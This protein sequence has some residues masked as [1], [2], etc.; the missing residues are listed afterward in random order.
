[1][2]HELMIDVK[3]ISLTY[4]IRSSFNLKKL[5]T[6]TGGKSSKYSVEAL[7]NVSF[8]LEKGKN[9][10][11]IGTNGS[12]KSTLMRVLAETYAPDS[13]ELKINANTV[14]LLT[15]GAGFMDNLSGR[16]N[17]Y[18]NALLLGISKNA[19]DNGL[20]EEI[21]AFSELGHSID[22]PMYTYSSGMKSRL[23]FSVAACV[24]PE[25]LL[26]DEVFS[27]GDA[28]FRQKS[29]DRIEEMIKSDKTVVMISHDQG[30]LDRYCDQVLWLHLG[31][32]KMMGDPK[33]V[34][35]AYT[36]FAKKQ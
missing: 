21:I 27:V 14:Q 33:E 4:E 16:M 9:L 22:Y 24:Q 17:M 20:A 6:K 25:L 35:A 2:S 28:H 32:V 19:L 31:E 3:N 30:V 18:L 5:F 12:G 26:L 10:G 34:M 1:M 15:L 11:I 29:Q 7:K 8:S 13:G 36:E 23:T